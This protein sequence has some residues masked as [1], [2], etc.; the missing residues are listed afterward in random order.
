MPI[1]DVTG[2]T[3]QQLISLDGRVAVVTGGARAIGQAIARR[4]AEAG[5]TVLIGDVDELG[6]VTAAEEIARN[7]AGTARGIALNVLDEDTIVALANRAVSEF[8][9]LDNLGQTMPASSPAARGGS[10]ADVWDKVQEVNRAARSSVAVRL[11]AGW[12]P[13]SE[14]RRHRP[15]SHQSPASAAGVA[16]RSGASSALTKHAGSSTWPARIRSACVRCDADRAMRP[17]RRGSWRLNAT[18]TMTPPFGFWAPS[19]G[20]L[21]ATEESAA[22]D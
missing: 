8:G 14:G 9:R 18:L 2:Q 3:L 10:L 6:A 11:P 13:E 12:S 21:T 20:S 5:A 16:H 19:A 22:A 1:K 17:R 7:S 15:M 4:L